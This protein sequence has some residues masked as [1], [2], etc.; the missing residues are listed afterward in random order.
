MGV[1]AELRPQGRG[2]AGPAAPIQGRSRA[3]AF[4]GAEL[5]QLP[6]PDEVGF[7]AVFLPAVIFQVV[8]ISLWNFPS[9]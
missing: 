4:W 6:H 5:R 1:M 2:S 9:P 7:K 8:F 3:E